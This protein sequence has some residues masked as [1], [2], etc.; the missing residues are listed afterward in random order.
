MN[1]HE[2]QSKQLFARYGIPVP[3]G[4]V[5]STGEEAAEAA[6]QKALRQVEGFRQAPQAARQ[7]SRRTR[8][9]RSRSG[10]R[11]RRERGVNNQASKPDTIS[12]AVLF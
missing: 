7:E 11:A 5:A 9:A 2:Y 6:R 3:N 12:A 8:C 1:L 4:Q 10:S